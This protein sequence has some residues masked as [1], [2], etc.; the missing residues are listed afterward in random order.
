VFE[1]A[2]REGGGHGQQR[3]AAARAEWAGGDQ[4]GVRGAVDTRPS[5]GFKAAR[6]ACCLGARSGE[7]RADVGARTA[8]R[9]GGRVVTRMDARRAETR[10]PE[11]S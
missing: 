1:T 7:A 9:V 4:C 11:R 8:R 10:A 2:K 5:V 6:A 3:R